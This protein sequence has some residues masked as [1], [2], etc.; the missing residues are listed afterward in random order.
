M[1]AKVRITDPLR[2][3]LQIVD[4]DSNGSHL[5]TTN[6]VVALDAL[7]EPA[8]VLGRWLAEARSWEP[9]LEQLTA[10]KCSDAVSP[11]L[12]D[13]NRKVAGSPMCLC[14]DR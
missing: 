13:H 11:R 3:R 1:Q 9:H 7:L 12:N 6:R 14:L 2:W 8:P 10:S 4:L 5:H